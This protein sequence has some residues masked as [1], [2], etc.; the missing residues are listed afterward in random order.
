MLQFCPCSGETQV[1]VWII[2]PLHNHGSKPITLIKAM[3][4]VA[5]LRPV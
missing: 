3:V 2:R 4:A 1:S 5:V